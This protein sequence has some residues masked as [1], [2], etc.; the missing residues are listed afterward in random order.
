M[1]LKALLKASCLLKPVKRQGIG[2]GKAASSPITARGTHLEGPFELWPPAPAPALPAAPSAGPFIGTLGRRQRVT[3]LPQVHFS[4]VT[5][6]H[7][8]L[9]DYVQRQL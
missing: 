3:M 4:L 6:T 8:E 2:E 5:A 9:N 7:L 1:V